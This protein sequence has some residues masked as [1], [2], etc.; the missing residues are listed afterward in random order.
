M[1]I[2]PLKRNF[3]R[4]FKKNVIQLVSIIIM[5]TLGIAVYVG[6]DSTWRSLQEYIDT[7][8][9]KDT[10]ADLTLYSDPVD[11]NYF[12]KMNDI[13]GISKYEESFNL[14]SEVSSLNERQLEVNFV[15]NN[16]I[17]KYK[18]IEGKDDLSIDS[19]LLDKSFAESNNLKVND[20]IKLKL[21]E[22]EK[23]FTIG[24]LIQSSS[25]IYITSDAT[26]V[27]P[28]HNKYGF[29]YLDKDAVTDFFHGN[30]LVNKVDIKIGRDGD[31]D[32][33][34]N[35]IDE[36]FNEVVQGITTLEES[37]NYL[38]I[39][40]KIQQ[41]K[42][43]GSLFPII[44][45]AIV[46]LMTFTTMY[47]IINKERLTIGI[48]KSLG[49]SSR[50]V[51]FHYCAYG[52]WISVIGIVFGTLIGWKIV[53][54]YIW[55]FFEELF[56]FESKNIVLSYSQVAVISILS[57]I[58]TII[59]ISY[60]F[61]KIDKE[62]PAEL[63]RAKKE[64]SG[65]NIFLERFSAYWNR[66]T[67]SEKLTLRQMVLN[68]VRV[69][70]TVL[71]VLG[72]TGL[73]L[74]ALGIR[75]TVDN[76]A[77]SVYSETYL[78]EEKV[79]LNTEKLEADIFDDVHSNGD[80]FMQEMKLSIESENKKKMS[81]VYIL[82]NNE[83]IRFYDD[84][85]E[86]KLKN[87]ELL[88]TEKISD[89]YSLSIG[90][91]VTVRLDKDNYI[92]LAVSHISKLNIGQG[93]YLLDETFEDLGQKYQP[94]VILKSD[95]DNQYSDDIIY[96]SIITED[97]EVDFVT[98]MESTMSMSIMLIFSAVLLAIVV[99]YNLG[100]LNFSDRERDIATLS[101]LGFY[102]SELNKFLSVENI[103]LSLIGI[104]FG[105]PAG[106]LMHRRMFANAG[107]GDELDFTALIYGKSFTLTIVFIII[108]VILI[109]YL[110]TRKIKKIKMTEALKSVE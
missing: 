39:N 33:I 93:F 92:Q 13:D 4:G 20:T 8:Y 48:L 87:N 77:K 71:G 29:I 79:Y 82:E 51:L 59:A 26:N 18:L 50:K 69:L 94:N 46:I 68:K 63:M 109:N 57:L 95:A 65:R 83:L 100:V 90:D 91:E 16:E 38:S 45:F 76:V 107:M 11:T 15:N 85:R 34:R 9:E 101:V 67:P 62:K 19:C 1:V 3:L 2:T 72:C 89:I 43:I 35:E 10:M 58:S 21:N 24:G 104:T 64:S 80:Y 27:I 41:Y 5:L 74:C 22:I 47:R 25:Y 54:N 75:D 44:F 66:K 52:L 28:D 106:I 88:I 105:I 81:S 73:L 108:L 40:Q 6:L 30:N 86:I 96:K 70:M 49:Y 60:V 102:E 61:L 42:S 14:V 110:L 12:D 55:N 56:V 53:P 7:H 32:A 99:L 36:V 103:Y 78:F 37:L 31:V 97:Q 17:N 23:E 84:N 98:S